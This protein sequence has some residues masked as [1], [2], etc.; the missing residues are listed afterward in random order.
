[1]INRPLDRVVL[2]DDCAYS[3][4]FQIENGVPIIPFKGDKEDAEL[5]LLSSYLEYLKEQKDFRK[6]NED[7]FR[8]NMYQKG[9][10]ILD[11]YKNIFTE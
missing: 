9:R 1:M 6:A 2:V 8:Y 3:Y 7:H 10:S 5:L 4:G 11:V